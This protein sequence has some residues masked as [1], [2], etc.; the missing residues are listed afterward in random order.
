VAWASPGFIRANEFT[1]PY[2]RA[3]EIC[4]EVG[5]QSDAK[6]LFDVKRERYFDAGAREV[7]HCSNDE[8]VSFFGPDGKLVTS[9][10]FPQFPQRI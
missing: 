7:W 10:L 1:T 5:I 2:E 9:R 4:V 6:G 8:S 3:P